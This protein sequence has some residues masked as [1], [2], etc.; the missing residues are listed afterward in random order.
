M[1]PTFEF[2]IILFSKHSNF[3]GFLKLDMKQ[4][5]KSRPQ[6]IIGIWEDK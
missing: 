4:S 6:K 5:S 1:F 2:V 3:S